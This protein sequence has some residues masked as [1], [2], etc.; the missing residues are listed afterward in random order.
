MADISM[1]N[2]V[3]WLPEGMLH[4]GQFLN[5]TLLHPKM[6][7]IEYTVGESEYGFSYLLTPGSEKLRFAYVRKVSAIS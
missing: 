5:A 1:V 4:F 2:I 3:L 6:N 7:K